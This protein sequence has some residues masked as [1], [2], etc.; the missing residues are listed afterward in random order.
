MPLLGIYAGSVQKAS[1][2]FESIA[3][4]T[5]TGSSGTIT[6]SSIP[7]TYQHLQIRYIAKDNS[8]DI[9]VALNIQ[10]NSDTGSNYYYHALIGDGSAASA[11]NS[12]GLN[13]RI[14]IGNAVTASQT[15][16][17]NMA[18][19]MGVGIIDI[20]DYASTSKYKVV[21]HLTGLD[22]NYATT[23][24]NIRMTSA[25]WNSTSAINSIRLYSTTGN[26]TTASTFALYGI[27]GA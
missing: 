11:T 5:G 21:R 9:G 19:I 16:A 3:T 23:V 13:N 15:S 25:N 1:T 7:S 26:F 8:I 24:A 22:A 10:F 20:H 2:A 4:A 17:P 27:K 12:G 6:F 14:V 18:N